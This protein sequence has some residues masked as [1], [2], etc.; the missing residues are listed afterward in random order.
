MNPLL[1]L[2]LLLGCFLAIVGTASAQG[3]ATDTLI[4]SVASPGE[5]E[6]F[7]AA[8]EGP[9]LSVP[10]AGQVISDG[11]PRL[12]VSMGTVQVTHPAAAE[13]LVVEAG[14]T[15]TLATAPPRPAALLEGAGPLLRAD[16]GT[17]AHFALAPTPAEQASAT[18]FDVSVVLARGAMLLAYAITFFGVPLVIIGAVVIYFRRRPQA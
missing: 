13:P 11:S 18:L 3:S 16:G 9:R 7:Y 6:T 15:L 5:G 1:R 8:A 4:V 10:I 12:Y 14:Q 2:C 17:V